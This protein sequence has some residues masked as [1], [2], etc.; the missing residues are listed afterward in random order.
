[1]IAKRKVKTVVEEANS[2][3]AQ[4]K[5]DLRI[6]LVV[7]FAFVS[8][9]FSSFAI[10]II[11]TNSPMQEVSTVE[12]MELLAEKN[13]E[14]ISA[15]SLEIEES[16]CRS[17]KLFQSLC[18][19]GFVKNL[20]QN[21]LEGKHTYLVQIGAH[22]GFEFNDP[23]ANGIIS[24]LDEI[25]TKHGSDELRKHFHWIFVEPHPK[26][27]ESL[28]KNLAAKQSISDMKGINVAIVPDNTPTE[29]RDK[30]IFYGLS[31]TIDP[32]TGFDSIS[33]K[34]LPRWVSQVSGFRKESI[35]FTKKQF[36]R[37]GLD[38]NDYIIQYKIE[39][40]SYSEL[41]EEIGNEPPFLVLVD[42][43]GYDCKIINSISASSKYYSKY[44]VY[45]NHC[46]LP[47]KIKTEEKL[48][49]LGY[50]LS[51]E[52]ENTYGVR[53]NSSQQ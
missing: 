17:R 12:E 15:I 46:D 3:R 42:T 39:T 31:D 21:M 40:K 52:G 38:L 9:L 44:I 8:F 30:M 53:K 23:L 32:E 29:E 7:F 49:E 43:E 20:S 2:G 16:C 37:V 22:T 48:K 4:K 45:E 34:T 24:L 36:K 6:L 41:M 18:S 33:N 5:C 13:K 1:M 11:S 14:N 27:F 25:S 26:N 50:T 51:N 19:F 28:S 35:M 47:D 10:L